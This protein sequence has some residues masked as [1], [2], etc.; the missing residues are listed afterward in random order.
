MIHLIFNLGTQEPRIRVRDG[1]FL[2]LK[3]TTFGPVD[4]EIRARGPK[5]SGLYEA[6]K[7]IFESRETRPSELRFPILVPAIDYVR[8]K[9]GGIDRLVLIVTDATNRTDEHHF[10]D[11][12]WAGK[13]AKAELQGSHP[14]LPVE[15]I[16]L[17]H[18]RPQLHSVA[19]R[20]I[21]E[22]ELF[23]A[24]KKEDSVF[25]CTSPGLPQVNAALVYWTLHRHRGRSL[26]FQV[27]EPER[28]VLERGEYESK[29]QPIAE[30]EIF[31][32][33]VVNEVRDLIAG[34]DYGTAL[35]Q[36]ERLPLD[37]RTDYSEIKCLLEAAKKQW[38]REIDA[39]RT[40]KPWEIEFRRAYAAALRAQATFPKD[41][42]DGIEWANDCC[43]FLRDALRAYAHNDRRPLE[44]WMPEGVKKETYDE[45]VA[46]R[47][48]DWPALNCLIELTRAARNDAVHRLLP[49]KPFEPACGIETIDE[50]PKVMVV[51]INAIMSGEE[52]Q[53]SPLPSFEE[54]NQKIEEALGRLSRGAI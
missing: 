34:H 1:R 7:V 24:V 36:I 12:Y 16:R 30:T 44:K 18:D 45:K 13:L 35:I 20:L 10:D 48:K 23:Y 42:T 47:F 33:F 21:G 49:V 28:D 39:R 31:E 6:A 19:K 51:L 52:M 17:C 29:E 46:G 27:E 9:E 38:E 3:D 8:E 41:R 15:T 25:V 43:T 50:L 5:A 37:P 26:L 11:T 4:R 22:S 32:D 2:L 53:V 54:H 14:S 40:D